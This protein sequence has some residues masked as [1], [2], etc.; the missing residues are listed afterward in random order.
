MHSTEIHEIITCHI[1]SIPTIH[2]FTTSPLYTQTRLWPTQS[3][4]NNVIA[5]LETQKNLTPG[6]TSM[7]HTRD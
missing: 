5:E 2:L 4:G 1:F 7:F 3:P 6:N